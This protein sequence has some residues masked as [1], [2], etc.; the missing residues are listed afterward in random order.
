MIPRFLSW[1]GWDEVVLLWGGGGSSSV[2]EEAWVNPRSSVVLALYYALPLGLSDP[3]WLLKQSSTSS[4]VTYDL[5]IH[6]KLTHNRPSA[7]FRESN[8]RACAVFVT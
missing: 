5:K 4:Y 3:K 8:V 2:W 6:L 1:G 7:H